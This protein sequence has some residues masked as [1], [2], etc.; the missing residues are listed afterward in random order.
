MY[1]INV[2]T[3]EGSPVSLKQYSIKCFL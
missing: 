3:H 1:L 2:F